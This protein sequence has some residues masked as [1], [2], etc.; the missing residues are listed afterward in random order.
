MLLLA[1]AA[2]HHTGFSHVNRLARDAAP[3][4][5][6]LVPPVWLAFSASLIVLALI[7]GIIGRRPSTGHRAMLLVIALFPAAGGALQIGY[8]GF[9]LPTAILMADAVVAVAAAV[10]LESR[11]VPGRAA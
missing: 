11:P 8:I 1:T 7:A 5:R 3:E 10:V 2:F 6:P 9:V 4:L